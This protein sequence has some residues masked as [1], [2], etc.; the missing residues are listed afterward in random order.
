MNKKLFFQFIF[1]LTTLVAQGTTFPI[2]H[3]YR[4]GAGGIYANAYIIE[5]QKGIVLVDATLSVSSATEVRGMINDI[6]KPLYAVLITHGHPDHYNGLSE[7]I[8]NLSVPI[9]ST[10]GVLDVIT[11]YDSEKEKQWKPMFGKEWPETRTFPTRTVK[12]GETLKFEDSS[13]TVHDLGA[14][15]SH[16]DS[17]WIMQT[18]ATKN[19]FLGDVVLHKV[20]AYLSDGHINAWLSHLQLL[21]QKLKDVSVLYPGHGLPGGLALLDW[22]KQ[23][24]TTYIAYL[25]PL[26][27]DKVITDEEKATLKQK[28]EVFLPNDKLTFLIELGAEATAK[29]VFN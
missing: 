12:D 22:Q 18:G 7:I 26:Y 28:M 2:V 3:P 1:F 23:Y 27:E 9:Y 11:K 4:S 29:A 10:Q 25:K 21:Q 6:G 13:F 5:F 20:H 24:L 16:S 8:K 14:G 15:E 17:Y 19:A